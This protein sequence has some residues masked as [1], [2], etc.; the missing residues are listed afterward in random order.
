MLAALLCYSST[1]RKCYIFVWGKVFPEL[2]FICYSDSCFVSDV[3]SKTAWKRSF[4]CQ[5]N[6]YFP[7]HST[8]QEDVRR[9]KILLWPIGRSMRRTSLSASL[10]GLTGPTQLAAPRRPSVSY[11]PNRVWFGSNALDLKLR[12]FEYN[13]HYCD[14]VYS[15]ILIFFYHLLCYT[16]H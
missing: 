12:D 4:G 11:E 2:T 7:R 8:V 10:N 9:R 16:S 13:S 1:E 5:S 3:G 15:F 6:R 14:F